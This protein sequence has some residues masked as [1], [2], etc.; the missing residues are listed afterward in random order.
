MSLQRPCEHALLRHYFNDRPIIDYIYAPCWE[1]KTLKSYWILSIVF[2]FW[3][4]RRI[5]KHAP[6]I[7]KLRHDIMG[8]RYIGMRWLPFALDDGPSI[9]ILFHVKNWLLRFSFVSYTNVMLFCRAASV[10]PKLIERRLRCTSTVPASL[11]GP[12]NPDT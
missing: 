1:S 3:L 6:C 11:L 12:C 8:D 5:R 7:L 9:S 10:C 4:R 2:Y